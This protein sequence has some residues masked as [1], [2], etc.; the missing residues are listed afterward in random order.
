VSAEQAFAVRE[1]S[2]GAAQRS[3][4]TRPSAHGALFAAA[5]NSNPR[6]VFSAS[7]MIEACR[8]VADDSAGGA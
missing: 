7:I 2:M 1:R 5:I 4:S 8:R 3:R 6:M